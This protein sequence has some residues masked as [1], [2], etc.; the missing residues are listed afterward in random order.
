MAAESRLHGRVPPLFG[1]AYGGPCA[2]S[3]LSGPAA[4]LVEEIDIEPLELA[5]AAIEGHHS[6]RRRN[7]ESGKICIAYKLDGGD[8]GIQ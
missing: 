5:K 8:R 7:C 4:E 1:A 6:P 3:A 2:S